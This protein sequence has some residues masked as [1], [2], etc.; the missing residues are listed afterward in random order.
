MYRTIWIER[1]HYGE[2]IQT[3]SAC[4]LYI[5]ILDTSRYRTRVIE[6]KREKA[7]EKRR[8]TAWALAIGCCFSSIHFSV[9]LLLHLIFA[10]KIK[11]CSTHAAA[12]RNVLQMCARAA[13]TVEA[14]RMGKWTKIKLFV[15]SVCSVQTVH[16]SREC[17]AFTYSQNNITETETEE[18]N[19]QQQQQLSRRGKKSELQSTIAEQRLGNQIG[20]KHCANCCLPKKCDPLRRQKKCRQTILHAVNRSAMRI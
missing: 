19:L 15:D 3:H 6:W 9:L 2:R 7:T 8:H 4:L 17:R 20:K 16:A 18:Q 1:R 5:S 10:T 12:R 13:S 11:L 14:V